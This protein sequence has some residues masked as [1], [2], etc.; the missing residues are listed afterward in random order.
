M[1]RY[2]CEYKMAQG[3]DSTKPGFLTRTEAFY[4][5]KIIFPKK[6]EE[7][8]ISVL[9]AEYGVRHRSFQDL[10]KYTQDTVCDKYM[11]VAVWGFPKTD[12]TAL[13]YRYFYGHFFKVNDAP[14]L[15]IYYVKEQDHFFSNDPSFETVLTVYRG[16][17][18]A[19]IQQGTPKYK[20]YLCDMFHLGKI[21][22]EMRTGKA[23][24]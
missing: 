16:I 17:D 1:R 11:P 24:E 3:I 14:Q 20:S 4:K 15:I 12:R 19:D 5:D 13:F 10:D 8:M 7:E 2:L 23:P 21:M 22:E 6:S 18:A 9:R